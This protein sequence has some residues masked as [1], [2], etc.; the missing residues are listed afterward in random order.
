MEESR[1]EIQSKE[2]QLKAVTAQLADM[3]TKVP[4]VVASC[5]SL[6]TCS[7]HFA[8]PIGAGVCMTCPD[9]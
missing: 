8:T 9:S 1:R 2:I 5:L 4:I 7:G 6:G 3:Q